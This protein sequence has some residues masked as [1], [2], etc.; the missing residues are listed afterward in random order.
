[1]GRGGEVRNRIQRAVTRA[2]VRNRWVHVGGAALL[3]AVGLGTMT[4]LASA[5]SP[6]PNAGNTVTVVVKGKT[7]MLSGTWSW[8]RNCAADRFGAGLQVD[9]N[10]PNDGGHLVKI[11]NGVAYAVG[12]ASDNV[13]QNQGCGT[14]N[15]VTKLST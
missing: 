6:N 5:D 2:A 8:N 15:S 9:W 10:D 7:V 11:V 4:A 1:M 3:I 14:Y 12:T 13:V